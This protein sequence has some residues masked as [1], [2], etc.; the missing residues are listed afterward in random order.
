[1]TTAI[2]SVRDWDPV[3]SVNPTTALNDIFAVTVETTVETEEDPL[4]LSCV[5]YRLNIE[6]PNG[7]TFSYGLTDSSV[8]EQITVKDRIFAETVRRHYNDKI[9]LTTLR[10]DRITPFRQD[11]ARFLSGE[12]K[13]TGENH[14]FPTKFLGMLYK[15]P[16]FYHYDKELGSVFD[17]EYHSLKGDEINYSTENKKLT[18]IKKIISYRKGR[19]PNEYWFNDHKDDRFMLSVEARSPLADLFDHYLTSNNNIAVK[20]YF[21]AARKDTL[22]YYRAQTWVLN[23]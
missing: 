17:S 8:K 13:K 15:L 7:L 4:L 14:E 11:L 9:V 18:F 6:D 1:M 2:M 10:G 21:R 12:F 19:N 16:Y 20:G 3:V 5:L 22:E 23:V